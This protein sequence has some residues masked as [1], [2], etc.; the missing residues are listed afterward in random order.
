MSYLD[1]ANSLEDISS[2]VQAHHEGVHCWGL[3]GRVPLPLLD[4]VLP[5]KSK[6]H[7]KEAL[8]LMQAS[9]SQLHRQ[10]SIYTC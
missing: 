1:T 6:Q 7:F 9:S 5:T 4:V 10:G 3:G 2:G 8:P